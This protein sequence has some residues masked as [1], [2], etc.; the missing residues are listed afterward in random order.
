MYIHPYDYMY[1]NPT[2]MRTFGGL[3]SDSSGDSR[4]HHWRHVVD[5]NVAYP[6]THNAGKSR[7]KSMKK[8]RAP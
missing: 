2:L 3:S 8:V 7:I 6:L 5:G 1:A 4:S